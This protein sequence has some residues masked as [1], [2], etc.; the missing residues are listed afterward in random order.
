MSDLQA[1]PFLLSSPSR[2]KYPA[3]WRVTPSEGIRALNFSK[4]SVSDW[5]I[6]MWVMLLTCVGITVSTTEFYWFNDPKSC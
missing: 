5:R 1:P 3:H 6:L 2:V 4:E